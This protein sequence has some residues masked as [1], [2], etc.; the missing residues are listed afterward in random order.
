V[1]RAAL[2]A[3]GLGACAAHL[4]CLVYWN[5]RVTI[6][7]LNY[8]FHMESFLP[9]AFFA[10]YLFHRR[11]AR[12]KYWAALVLALCIKEDVGVYLLGFGAYLVLA[13]RRVA[14]G[15]ATALVSLAWTGVAVQSVIPA[16]A[17]DGAY[18]VGGLWSHWGQGL[19]IFAGFA[20]RPVEL[21]VAML[22][23]PYLVFFASLLFLPFASRWGWLLFIAP[24]GVNATSSMPQQ[25]GL[26]LYYG[27]PLLAFAAVASAIA[28]R[29]RGAARIRRQ[30]W[31]AAIGS[32]VVLLDVSHLSF[33][34]IPR[35]RGA[36]VTAIRSIPDSTVV[37][38]MPC[39]YPVAGYQQRKLV[40]RPGE[41]L[42]SPYVLIRSR[43]T[44]WPFT[45][46]QAESTAAAAIRSGLYR[47]SSRIEGFYFLERARP[48]SEPS[49]R[50]KSA[51]RAASAPDRARHAAGSNDG[52]AGTIMPGSRRQ[53]RIG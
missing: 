34:E 15:A 38:L 7:T 1:L 20:S 19:G 21:L 39:F 42:T 37:Q 48:G 36:M 22:A 45:R 26:S 30:P 27:I 51:G 17:E 3:D 32:L 41:P 10:I 23:K 5:H 24:W 11:G 12:A 18:G 28:W 9:L 33:P 43:D 46:E 49:R 8:P 29:G 47:N 40:L 14:L 2:R 25:S 35:D 31:A 50:A 16:L 4:A 6:S 13:E 52:A 44:T 53:R